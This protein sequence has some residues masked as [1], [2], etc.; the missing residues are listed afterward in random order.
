MQLEHLF[1]A[2][3]QYRP[4]MQTVVSGEHREGDLI[5]SGEGRI[6]GRDICGSIRWSMYAADCPYRADGRRHPS[7]GRTEE[8]YHLCKTNPGRVIET[9]DGAVIWFDGRGSACGES[10]PVRNGPSPLPFASRRLMKS[11]GG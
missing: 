4:D 8:G 7:A 6:T 10:M 9:E 11:T 3:L 5:G 1:D 2:E